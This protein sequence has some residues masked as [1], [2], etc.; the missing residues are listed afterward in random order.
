MTAVVLLLGCF[1]QEGK[2]KKVIDLSSSSSSCFQTEFVAAA[3]VNLFHPP[4]LCSSGWVGRVD[5]RHARAYVTDVSG[6]RTVRARVLWT[7][8]APQQWL[9]S[10]PMSRGYT[11]SGVSHSLVVLSCR[12]SH[13][14]C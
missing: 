14:A 2:N 7:M 6:V 4:R 13:T 9:S 10:A 1:H 5:P 3:R 8:Q 12:V 11:I